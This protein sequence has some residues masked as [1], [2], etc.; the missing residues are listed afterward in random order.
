MNEDSNNFKDN[1]SRYRSVT[2]IGLADTIG[3]VIAAVF[4]FKKKECVFHF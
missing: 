1:Q 4:W 2:T 3:S